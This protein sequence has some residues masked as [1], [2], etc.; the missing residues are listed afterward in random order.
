MEQPLQTKSSSGKMPFR[1]KLQ[2]LVLWVT[3]VLNL[4]H[5]IHTVTALIA[6]YQNSNQRRQ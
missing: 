4:L 2:S 6:H 3:L 1:N 5:F